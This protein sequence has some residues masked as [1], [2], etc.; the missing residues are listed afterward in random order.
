MAL[1]IEEMN[2][3]AA[4]DHD[5]LRA[6]K[7]N[8]LIFKLSSGTSKIRY[9]SPDP[10]RTRFTFITSTNEAQAQL[11]LAGRLAV[12]DAAA[13]RMLTIPVE[14]PLGV[15]GCVP[16][17][18][19]S[20]GALAQQFNR[21]VRKCHGVGI[22]QLLERLVPEMSERPDYV[23]RRLRAST[24]YFRRKVEV[25]END[26]SATRVADAFG[27]VYAVA[28]LVLRY[29]AA[30]K[31]LKPLTAALTCYRLNQAS[32]ARPVDPLRLLTE[33]MGRWDV[34]HIPLGGLSELSNEQIDEN[35]CIIKEKRNGRNELL[36]IE[37]Q[38]NRLVHN[39]RAF[40]ADP[41]IERIL[42]ADG[43]RKQTK[44]QIRLNRKS[45]RVYCFR[46]PEE[47]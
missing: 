3:Y 47:P 46:V 17:G 45:E 4:T 20:T 44:R 32:R 7:I 41:R 11:M 19:A 35:D 29:G 8:D 25:E 13:D 42:V 38:F 36:F 34:L 16:T 18:S 26:G 21:E 2:L 22:R 28:K 14:K 39:R 30:S 43:E 31:R 15:F 1:I 10:H 6:R 33:V 40:F 5:A 24:A 27:L 23:A 12:S 37:S 9:G